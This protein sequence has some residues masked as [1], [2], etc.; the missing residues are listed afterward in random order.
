MLISF[1]TAPGQVAEDGTGSH[2]PFTQ[3]LL[4]YLPLPKTEVLDMF[5]R[6]RADVIKQTDRRQIPWENN[7]LEGEVYLVQ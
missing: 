2:S 6:V 1:A 7:S 3:A 4:K 5:R